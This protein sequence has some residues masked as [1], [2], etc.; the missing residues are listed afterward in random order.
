MTISSLGVIEDIPLLNTK[1][2]IPPPHP[3]LVS[4]PRL[5]QQLESGLALGHRLTLVSAPA[6]FGKT[7]LLAEWL[8][9][10]SGHVA[11]LSLDQ[12]DSDPSHF[13]AYFIAALETIAPKIA[14]NTRAWIQSQ[15]TLTLKAVLTQLIN[16]LVPVTSNKESKQGILLVLDDYHM[17]ANAAVHDALA[18][19]LE[20]MPPPPV[21]LHLVIATRADPSL[22]LPRLRARSQLTEIRAADLRFTQ[23][24]T[25]AFLNQVM[26]LSLSE[27]DIAT[28][29]KRTEGWVASLQLAALSLRGRKPEHIGDFLLEFSGTH[30]H[31]I[32]YLAEEVLTQQSETVQN[33]LCQTSI[34]DRLTASLCQAVTGHADSDILLQQLEQENLFIVPLDERRAWYRYHHLFADF[35][36]NRLHARMPDKI[37]VLHQSAAQ[38]YEHHNLLAE[39]IGHTLH[40]K[41]FER[42]TR[43][44]LHIAQDILMHSEV[45]PLLHWLGLF[46]ESWILSHPHLSLLY[47]QALLIFGDVERVSEYLEATE[48]HFDTDDLPAADQSYLEGQIAAI[49]AYMYIY[50]GNLQRGFAYAQQ[51]LELMPQEDN[52]QKSIVTWIAGF[53]QFFNTDI[54]VA[55]QAF[56]ETLAISQAIGNDLIASLSAFVTGYVYALQGHLRRARAYFEQYLPIA[57]SATGVDA[58]SGAQLSPSVCLLYQGLGEVLREMNE[59]GTAEH[60]LMQSVN[61]A[62]QWGNVEVLVDTYT[63]LARIRQAQ[64]DSEGTAQAL[65]QAMALVHADKLSALT[66]RQ[67]EAH[68]ARIWI[69]QQHLDLASNW[70]EKWAHSYADM[71]LIE[72][73]ISLFVRWI[74][75]SALARLWL[76]QHKYDQMLPL[77]APFLQTVEDIG[78]KGI[79]IEFLSLKTLALS[80]QGKVAPAIQSIHRALT[81]AEPEGYVRVFVDMGESMGVLLQNA[82]AQNITPAYIHETLLPAFRISSFP[83]EKT[84]AVEVSQTEELVEPL[85]DRE[86]EVLHLIAEGLTNRE[87]A[88][89]LFIALSTVK[90]HINNIYGKLEVS[91]RVQAVTKAKTLHLV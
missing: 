34:L 81:L 58:A 53:G 64:G 42:A 68:R 8:E 85:S 59:L 28:L 46:P 7:M 55:Q 9:Q 40:A 74:E 88:A 13:F 52:F 51:A 11:W 44:I 57:P 38:W 86:F 82:A 75:Y 61:L 63:V 2:Y 35:L 27:R 60:M 43:L 73:N 23:E 78:W 70:A 65:Q 17:I 54:T 89:R 56:S 80:G 10:Y 16:Q 45:T 3:N 72:G 49:R 21:G 76:A 90:S 71:P 31:V 5:V 6:G 37:A 83:Q 62:Q 47:A 26:H 66:V 29:E 18:F 50:Q 36:R 12:Q 67:I 30:H 39:A 77:I 87:I 48:T 41:D 20:T 33:F 91:N 84:A 14:V 15:Q 4:R 69:A 25:A 22:P 24:E 32:D 79:A 1:L 19:L